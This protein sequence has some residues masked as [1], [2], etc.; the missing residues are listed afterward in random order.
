MKFASLVRHRRSVRHYLPDPVP[1]E[2]I[3]RCLEA[4]RL[5]P[6]A[7]NCQPWY[8]HVIDGPLR[9]DLSRAMNA[10]FYGKGINAF[11]VEAPVL[12]AVETLRQESLAPRLAGTVRHIR[13]EVID[14]AIAVDHFTLQAAD[15]GLGSCWIGWF[16]EKAV[17]KTLSL[18]EKSRIDI[19]VTLGWPAEGP[20]P[21]SRKPLEAIRRYHG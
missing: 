3:E 9:Q 10:G 11:I 13:Y 12:V 18:P 8:F 4:A 1:R 2:L 7:C 15:L 6:S 20:S 21:K 5:A 17:K 16:N 19:V 14:I